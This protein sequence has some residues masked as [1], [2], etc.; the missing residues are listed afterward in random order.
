MLN[1]RY[2]MRPISGQPHGPTDRYKVGE[3]VPSKGSTHQLRENLRQ[4]KRPQP[5]PIRHLR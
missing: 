4:V 1:R 5:T 2:A 3:G